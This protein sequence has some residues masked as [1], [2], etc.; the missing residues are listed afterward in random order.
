MR[1]V[2]RPTL[3]PPRGRPAHRS[4]VGGRDAPF[5]AGLLDEPGY[6][7]PAVGVA[8]PALECGQD[9]LH[10]RAAARP[11]GV[12][13]CLGCDGDQLVPGWSASQVSPARSPS[14]WNAPDRTSVLSTAASSC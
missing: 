13:V 3:A 11:D 8:A 2:R 5:V 12:V 9:R 7:T 1:E 10:R 14:T 4:H 6:V